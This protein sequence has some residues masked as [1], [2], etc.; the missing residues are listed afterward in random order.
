ME[1][2]RLQNKIVKS[3]HRL[4]RVGLALMIENGAII[5]GH[6]ITGELGR[7]GMGVVYKAYDKT[8]E[9]AAA[10]KMMLPEQATD[11]N[12]K[13]F[14]REAASIAKC[15]H[16]GIIKV[17]TYGEHGDL[18]YFIMEFVDGKPLSA[19]LELAKTLKNAGNLDELKKYGYIQEPSPADDE[20]P[21]FLRPLAAPPLSDEEYEGRAATLIAGV[22]DALY[23][24]HSLGI[25]HRDIKPSNILIGKKGLPKLADFGLAKIRDSVDITTGQ[26]MLGTLKYMAPEIFADGKITL[27]ADIYSLGTVFYELLTLEHP[28]KT[29]NTA[30]FIKAVTQDPCP[31]PVKINPA[32]S[33]ALNLVILKCL[34]KK[35]ADR[36]QSARDLADAIRLGVRPKGLKTQIFEGIKTMLR[37]SERTPAPAAPEEA[38]L[39]QVSEEDRTE[40]DRLMGNAIKAYFM[41]FAII[42]AL[43]ITMEALE[44]DPGSLDAY[45]MAAILSNHVEISSVLRRGRLKLKLLENTEND[46]IARTRAGLIFAY[47]ED[48]K[49]WPKRAEKY[50]RLKPDDPF[51]LALCAQARLDSDD[52]RKAGEY[53]AKLTE[54]MPGSMYNWYI[55]MSR[56]NRMGRKKESQELTRRVIKKFPANMML[57]YGLSQALIESGNLDEAEKM[58]T[59]GIKLSPIEEFF[60]YFHSEIFLY[61]KNYPAACAELR[62][63]I[64]IATDEIKSFLY[65]K[66]S[67]VYILR[68][69]PAEA[70]KH[71][72][73]ARN[74][75]PDLNFKSNEELTEIV[76]RMKNFPSSLE[77]IPPALLH[78]NF[79]KSKEVLLLD[80][81]SAH[82]N[83]GTASSA[84]YVF[85]KDCHPRAACLWL[86]F[87]APHRHNAKRTE[88]FLPSLPLSSFADWQG[89]ILKTD[90][91]RVDSGYGKYIATIDFTAPLKHNTPAPI[92]AET[93]MDGLWEEKAGGEIELHLDET[94]QQLGYRNRIL[95]LPEDTEII[96][97]SAEPDETIVEDGTRYLI[98]SRFFFTDEHFRLT[99]KFRHK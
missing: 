26:P 1:S 67:K 15:N 76:N 7:G 70:R 12:K 73:I 89:N 27:T 97:I 62:K 38:Q 10:I 54:M 6:T 55:E 64:G 95:A 98:Y 41:D 5:N 65:Y 8:L 66:L 18:P 52:Y 72:E 45:F 29:D 34:A 56:L 46:E 82:N 61:T 36:F 79:K 22:A 63:A 9:R 32:I 80:L 16:P 74:L 71:L 37:P 88:I 3:N 85:E 4:R 93:D 57:R 83:V 23:E 87:Y 11:T 58:I 28:F 40:A 42:K 69:E 48:T 43:T 2:G 81:F 91:R 68:G 99:V 30:A 59:E 77:G 53:S 20:L 14:I 75:A 44:L 86:F 19:F 39:P 31:E 96:S 60:I 84:I 47:I 78:F 25:T 90:F 13:R 50:L 33:P 17:Y 24:A 49:D 94:M 35:P 92:E 21:Y 51:A